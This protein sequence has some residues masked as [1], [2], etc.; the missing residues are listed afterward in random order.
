MFKKAE[1]KQQKLRILLEGTSGTGKTYSALRLAKGIGGKVAVLDTEKGSASLYANEFDF[2]TCIFNP[3]YSPNNYI[4]MIKEA[5][6]AGYDILIIDSSSKEWSGAGG[7]LEIQQNLGGRLQDWA[8]VS[9]M[10]EKFIEAILQANM[11]I[12]CTART[13]SDWDLSKDENGKTK[14][15]KLGLKTEQ[16][17]GIDYEFTTVL[18]LNYDHIA[19]ATKDRTHIFEKVYEPITE[20]TGEKLLAW[21]NDGAIAKYE[22]KQVDEPT[23]VQ[24]EVEKVVEKDENKNFE[25]VLLMSECEDKVALKRFKKAHEQEWN[26]ELEEQ[27]NN[28]K[29]QM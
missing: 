17:D 20:K 23:I 24:K 2:D 12:I 9:P 5:E 14:A 15:Q 22:P 28:L 3:P 16:R 10:H 21:L 19:E 25:L 8:K 27:F 6:K 26:D 7:C 13:K 4:L 11:H 29:G 18:R 1:R